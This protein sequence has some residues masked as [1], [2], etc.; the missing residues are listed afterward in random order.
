MKHNTYQHK[1]GIKPYQ[2]DD[3]FPKI[4][5][6]KTKNQYKRKPKYTFND[7]DQSE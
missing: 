4:K 3:G 5:Q 6:I 7:W 2:H 1:K